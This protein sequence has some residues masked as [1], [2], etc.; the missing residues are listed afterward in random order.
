MR[1][2]TR[3]EYERL[4]E[5]GFLGSGD[6]VELLEG[7][8]LV[9]EPQ[10]SPHATAT[11]LAQEALRAAF[12][13]GWDVRAGLPLALGRFSEPEPD[14]SVVH[15]SPRDYRDAHPTEAALVVEVA[16]ASLRL[17]RTRKA[18]IY[19]RAGIPDYWI[20]NLVTRVLEVYRDPVALDSAHRR[21]EY[22]MV[23][24]LGPGDSVTP[25]AAPQASIAV[26]DLL[27]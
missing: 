11:R 4:V 23:R 13:P 22:R 2:W 9:Q 12:G 1:R 25:L 24:S 26:A 21:W 6:R 8:L 27:P 18:R 17:D 10:H 19:A 5:Q 3:H 15:G 7:W 16:H 20:V 14:V